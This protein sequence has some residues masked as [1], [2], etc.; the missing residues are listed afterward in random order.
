VTPNLKELAWCESRLKGFLAI[1]TLCPRNPRSEPGPGKST[2][3]NNTIPNQQIPKP[4]SNM[5]IF[6]IPAHLRIL[7][8]ISLFCEPFRRR[9]PYALG[10]VG[11]AMFTR[12]RQGPPAPSP[13]TFAL[14]VS[15][16]IDENKPFS[17]TNLFNV[18]EWFNS[19]RLI[20]TFL[21]SQHLS[22]QHSTAVHERHLRMQIAFVS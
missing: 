6:T 8:K 13:F 15:S 20:L 18:V 1:Y 2:V 19:H 21:Q 9:N 22:T 17:P 5:N 14:T 11:P 12:L 16:H 10:Q 4:M 7:S 3:L